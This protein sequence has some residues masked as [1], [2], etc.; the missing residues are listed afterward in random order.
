[1]VPVQM[2][3]PVEINVPVEISVPAE[4]TVPQKIT[5]PVFQKSPSR[6]PK[7]RVFYNVFEKRQSRF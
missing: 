7:I 5:V 2:S 6:S 1:M 3:V 4:I